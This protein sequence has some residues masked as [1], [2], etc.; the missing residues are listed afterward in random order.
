MKIFEFPSQ[1]FQTCSSAIQGPL[2]N[3]SALVQIKAWHQTYIC[4]TRP[5]I[6][7]FRVVYY[8][9]FVIWGFIF[10]GFRYHRGMF[11][12]HH[13][14]KYWFDLILTFFAHRSKVVTKYRRSFMDI[15]SNETWWIFTEL[16]KIAFYGF[17]L[18]IPILWVISLA[19][20]LSC[21]PATSF[22]NTDMMTS[23]NGNIFRVTGLWAGNSPVTGEFPA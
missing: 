22:I 5:L 7:I 23:S 17:L 8:L 4:V 3:M 13:A 21:S 18:V 14:I 10:C 2:H 15:S 1:F 6:R 19:S 9:L 16:L 12:S 20:A 11:T